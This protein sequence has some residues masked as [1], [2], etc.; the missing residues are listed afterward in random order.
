ML[1]GQEHDYYDMRARNA[2]TGEVM[3]FFY[4]AGR[5]N[6][7]IGHFLNEDEINQMQGV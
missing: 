4:T 2:E 3:F 7:F 6:L 1:D 5:W